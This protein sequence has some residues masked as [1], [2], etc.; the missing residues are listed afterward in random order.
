MYFMYRIIQEINKLG[1]N[2]FT[3]LNFIGKQTSPLNPIYL[4]IFSA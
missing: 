2:F 3:Y 4:K 1:Y